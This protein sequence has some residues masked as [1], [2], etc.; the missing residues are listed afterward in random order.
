MTPFDVSCMA[1]GHY[2]F[3]MGQIRDHEF[4]F[5]KLLNK[6]GESWLENQ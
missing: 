3:I 2:D 5:I 4:H 1:D 6:D